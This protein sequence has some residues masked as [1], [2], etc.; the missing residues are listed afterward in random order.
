MKKFYDKR[1]AV[2]LLNFII[3]VSLISMIIPFLHMINIET[4]V[5][6]DRLIET[7]LVC[8]AEAGMQKAIWNL[9]TPIGQGGQGEDWST[10][11]TTEGFGGGT[12]TMEAQRFDWALAENNCV[13]SATD[14]VPGHDPQSVIDGDDSTYWQTPDKPV[15][16]Q[17]E[18]VTLAFP[19]PLTLSKVHLVIP[20]GAG[21]HKPKEYYWEVSSNGVD[22]TEVFHEKKNLLDERTDVFPPV[23]NVNYLR[24]KITKVQ[25]GSGTEVQI[26]TVEVITHKIVSTASLG[27]F[28]CTI[29]QTVIADESTQTAADQIDWQ[30]SYS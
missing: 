24:L 5:S 16:P 18:A 29:E 4:K 8:L 17:F 9:K 11:G 12:Y 30:M 26:G 21:I 2:L 6:G 22:Y 27:G 28:T 7:Q 14:T 20:P 15:R 10:G 25:G 19:S 13:A 1:G 3:L 23:S